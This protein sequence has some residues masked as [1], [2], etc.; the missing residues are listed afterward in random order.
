M[1]DLFVLIAW[2]HFRFSFP[3]VFGK[4]QTHGSRV[5]FYFRRFRIAIRIMCK[6]FVYLWIATALDAIIFTRGHHDFLLQCI[7]ALLTNDVLI[8]DTFDTHGREC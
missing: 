6:V 3:V 1:L 5:G 2:L 7:L 8:I 4:T